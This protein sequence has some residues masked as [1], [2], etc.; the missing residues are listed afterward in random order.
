VA[1]VLAKRAQAPE[2]TGLGATSGHLARD[3]RHGPLH[4]TTGHSCEWW[5]RLAEYLRDVRRGEALLVTGSQ[6]MAG[7]LWPASTREAATSAEVV[8]RMDE[9]ARSSELHPAS[10]QEQ[11]I[12]DPAAAAIAWQLAEP[13]PTHSAGVPA[14]QA[15]SVAWHVSR[16]GG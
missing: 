2:V 5:A 4:G 3:A 9:R 1:R 6:V 7:G 10:A 8:R 15:A 16:A 12:L 13:G 14:Q 11:L